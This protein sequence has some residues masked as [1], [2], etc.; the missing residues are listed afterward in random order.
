MTGKDGDSTGDI[1]MLFKG[2][3][4]SGEEVTG[5]ALLFMLQHSGNAQELEAPR[6]LWKNGTKCRGRR[7]KNRRFEKTRLQATLKSRKPLKIVSL[8]VL[9]QKAFGLENSRDI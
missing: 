5:L 4:V 7:E 9:N 3:K 1:K 8:V 6:T 2:W